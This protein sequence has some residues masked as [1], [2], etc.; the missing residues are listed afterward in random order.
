MDRLVSHEH[1]GSPRY[2]RFAAKTATIPSPPDCS[3][4]AT[5]VNSRSANAS[6]SEGGAH[7]E[8]VRIDRDDRGHRRHGVRGRHGTRGSRRDRP[9]PEW[10]A[11]TG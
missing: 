11:G 8:I 1:A 5:G 3:G 7:V 10:N 2:S 4:Q 6:V 9:M